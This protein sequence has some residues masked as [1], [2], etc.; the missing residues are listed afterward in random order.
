MYTLADRLRRSPRHLRALV[1]LFALASTWLQFAWHAPMALAGN[2]P[3]L[4]NVTCGGPLDADDI[5]R[6][7]ALGQLPADEQE[8]G[9]GLCDLL[10]S[11]VADTVSAPAAPL[12]SVAAVAPP[13]AARTALVASSPARLPPARAPPSA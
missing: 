11:P 10:T 13:S 1:L 12:V 8:P 3:A 6:L 4:A 5:A 2:S 9:H 7:V